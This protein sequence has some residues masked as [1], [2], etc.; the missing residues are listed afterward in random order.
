MYKSVFSPFPERSSSSLLTDAQKLVESDFDAPYGLFGL[1]YEKQDEKYGQLRA[2]RI[3]EKFRT[4]VEFWYDFDIETVAI[5]PFEG[6]RHP[7]HQHG[8]VIT[9]LLTDE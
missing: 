5:E 9:W 7:H 6:L 1:Y 4:D 3:A 8:A 2:D